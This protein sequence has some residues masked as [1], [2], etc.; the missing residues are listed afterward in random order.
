MKKY[1]K[2]H[3]ANLVKPPSKWYCNIWY[4]SMKSTRKGW[5]NGTLGL[6][7]HDV[8]EH[9]CVPAIR[10]KIYKELWKK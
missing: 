3:P 4:D 8:R 1:I 10:D 5:E 7:E 2:T 9:P 6:Y